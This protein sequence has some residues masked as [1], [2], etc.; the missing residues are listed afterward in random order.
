MKITIKPEVFQKLHPK[1]KVVFIL[2]TGIDNKSKVAEANHL[3]K[4]VE[5]VTLLTFNKDTFKS[6]YLVAPWTTAR[7][8]F[9]RKAKH[10]HTS[11][12][13]LLKK[14]LHYQNITAKD[15][16]SALLRYLALKH[17]VPVGA[18]DPAKI[19]GK[20]TFTISA[21]KKIKKGELYYH[22]DKNVLG[23]KLDYWKNPRT[24]LSSSSNS[25]LLHFEILPPLTT[26]KQKELVKEVTELF[27]AFCGG[28]VKVMVLDKKKNS[29]VI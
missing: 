14:V 10:Y 20:I 23:T 3:L 29:A 19:K 4:E 5:R 17:I 8:E 12:E 9:G 22:D 6:H 2:A 27:P 1:F 16:T 15:T 18:D 26:A 28:K 11:V 13:Q 25:A 7:E 24:A 21:G